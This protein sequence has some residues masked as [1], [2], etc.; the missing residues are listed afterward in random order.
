MSLNDLLFNRMGWAYVDNNTL[1]PVVLLEGDSTPYDAGL[2]IAR[3]FET[4]DLWAKRDFDITTAIP[5]VGGIASLG[6]IRT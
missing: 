1:N 6:Y 3:D 5:V 4:G 2:A